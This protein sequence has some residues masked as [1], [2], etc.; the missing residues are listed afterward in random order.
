MRSGIA[1]L[2]ADA[3]CSAFRPAWVSRPGAESGLVWAGGEW[4]QSRGR[5]RLPRSQPLAAIGRVLEPPRGAYD[6]QAGKG[7]LDAAT[8]CGDGLL[9]LAAT[10][11]NLDLVITVDTLAAHLA[12]ALGKPVWV[13]LQQQADW[14]W[15]AAGEHQPLVPDHA[16]L[17]AD[18]Y[19]AT[20]PQ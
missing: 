8:I 7:V 4:N 18:T 1:R 17:P 13:L 16:T 12:G 6:R 3:S 19:R 2:P 14:R 15:Q 11:A 10:I 20:G 5:S 9:A